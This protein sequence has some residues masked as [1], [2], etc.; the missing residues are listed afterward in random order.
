[1]LDDENSNNNNF[2]Y[3]CRAD[4]ISQ[5]QSRAFTITTNGDRGGGGGSSDRNSKIEIA[6]FNVDGAFFAISNVCVHKGGPLNE[7]ALKGDIITCPWHGWKYS[8][9]NGKSA[10]KGGDS[11]SSYP[12]RV[13]EGRIYVSPIPKAVGKRISK[14]HKAYQELESAVKQHIRN[15]ES[16]QVLPVDDDNATKVR[17][18]GL[19]TT[20]MNDE[21]TPRKST[22]ESSLQFALDY[23]KRKYG[24]ETVMLKLR[25]LNFRHCEGYYSKN[26]KACIFP[27]SISEMDEKDQMIEI[28]QRMIVWADVVIVATPI[29]WGSA[30]SLYYQMVQRMNCVQNQIITHN[31]Y[32]IRDKV[33]AFIITGGQDNVQHVAGELLSFWSQL[34]FV[35]GKFPFSGWSRGWYAEDTENNV[36]DNAKSLAFKQDIM[37]TVSGAVEMSRLIKK[38]RYDE[39]VI[40]IDSKNNSNNNGATIRESVGSTHE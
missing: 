28:Y 40:T 19:S 24:A 12:V 23:A 34:G 37:R 11:I 1:M 26:A 16:S 17:V 30:S 38:N 25:Q 20:N 33:S 9:R 36:S 29:R 35:F 18:L 21:V 22:S 27:C 6:V 3:I 13:L 10:H 15:V 39:K 14:P 4:Q 32:L 8:V 5:G 7:G 31:N 2:Q